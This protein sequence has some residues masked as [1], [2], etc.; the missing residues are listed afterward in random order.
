[1]GCNFFNNCVSSSSTWIRRHRRG[2]SGNRESFVLSVSGDVHN[3]FYL[4]LAR[5]TCPMIG[6]V[7]PIGDFDC[8]IGLAIS[9]GTRC[10]LHLLAPESGGFAEK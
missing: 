5:Q 4:R 8:F 10:G 3:L 2:I 6:K 7:Q 9:L 1:L